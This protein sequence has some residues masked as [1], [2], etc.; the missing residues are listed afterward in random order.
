MW[1]LTASG[2]DARPPARSVYEGAVAGGEKASLHVSLVLL[3]GQL[4]VLAQ[5]AFAIATGVN[6]LRGAQTL[7][8]VST[9]FQPRDLSHGAVTGTA[10][11]G[12]VVGALFMLAGLRLQRLSLRGRVPIALAELVLLLIS[13][14]AI[15]VGG[16]N[17]SVISVAVL[18]FAGSPILPGAAVLGV[19][20]VVIYALLIHPA[21]D[22][23]RRRRQ[24]AAVKAPLRVYLPAQP[25]RS[26]GMSGAPA[27]RY[28]GPAPGPPPAAR[29]P[30]MPQISRA[31]SPAS[32][33]LSA[34]SPPAASR[35]GTASPPAVAAAAPPSQPPEPKLRVMPPVSP[36]LVIPA[37]D[38]VVAPAAALDL[39]IATARP[40]PVPAAPPQREVLPPAPPAA[41]LAAAPAAPETPAREAPAAEVPAPEAPAA[42]LTPVERVRA[43]R[44]RAQPVPPAPASPAP[45]VGASPAAPAKSEPSLFVGLRPS[46]RKPASKR[47]A[48]QQL[49][50]PARG[51]GAELRDI[52]LKP[53]VRP[54]VLPPP[55]DDEL[56]DEE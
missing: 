10:I 2:S 11:A 39:R 53:G 41:A 34:A 16:E 52:R 17:L 27:P 47:S 51:A 14:V 19:Q 23:L 4:L 18:A 7:G 5:G 49:L 35:P 30:A 54:R 55:D 40:D 45:P 33:Q 9:G 25:P 50:R 37:R 31:R 8:D 56:V 36:R 20:A 3:V 1:R 44:A 43:V 28:A 24:A 26:Q 48:N 38:A 6:L 32:G 42:A 13:S 46:P 21:T 12:I 22:I 15:A 29:A